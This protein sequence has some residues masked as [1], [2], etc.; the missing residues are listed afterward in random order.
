MKTGPEK[1]KNLKVALSAIVNAL[2][3]E[4]MK[5]VEQKESPK[6]LVKVIKVVKFQPD[7]D[8]LM[9]NMQ[10]AEKTGAA[11][12]IRQALANDF[13]GILSIVQPD[14]A[15]VVSS[16]T[17][18]APLH[19]VQKSTIIDLP[20]RLQ[21]VETATLRLGSDLPRQSAQAQVAP[22]VVGSVRPVSVESGTRD[23]YVEYAGEKTDGRDAF[24]G[25]SRLASIAPVSGLDIATVTDDEGVLSALVYRTLLRG[26]AVSPKAGRGDDFS[27][28]RD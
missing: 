5:T 1:T 13:Q 11:E 4:L 6:P 21:L 12:A 25:T 16:K 9:K 19:R 26:D 22:P 10:K 17:A 15:V 20:K 27:W 28:P 23:D 24:T 7:V 14:K 3:P 2:P 8:Y 18:I